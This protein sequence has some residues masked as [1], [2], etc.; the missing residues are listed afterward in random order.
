[1]GTRA[2]RIFTVAVVYRVGEVQGLVGGIVVVC[3]MTAYIGDLNIT[4]AVV[5]QH[6]LRHFP[7]GKAAMEHHF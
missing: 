1:M 2:E 6:L 7:A 5:A 3:E 4:D